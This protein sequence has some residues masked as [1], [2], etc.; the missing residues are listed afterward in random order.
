MNINELV[1][2]PIHEMAEWM[3]NNYKD[4]KGYWSNNYWFCYMNECFKD[5]NFENSD[6]RCIPTMTGYTCRNYGGV[7]EEI[8]RDRF[9]SL[10]FSIAKI[11][12]YGECIIFKFSGNLVHT[13]GNRWGDNYGFDLTDISFNTN[14]KIALSRVYIDGPDIVNNSQLS[15]NF[16]LHSEGPYEDRENWID[17]YPFLDDNY[18]VECSVKPIISSFS[19]NKHSLQEYVEKIENYAKKVQDIGKKAYYDNK[20]IINDNEF[21]KKCKKVHI[22]PFEVFDLWLALYIENQTITFDDAIGMIRLSESKEQHIRDYVN[23]YKCDIVEK[24]WDNKWTLRAKYSSYSPYH[25]SLLFGKV[26]FTLTSGF[27]G[28]LKKLDKTRELYLSL[29]TYK[30]DIKN[31]KSD[32]K[33]AY[34]LLA[35]TFENKILDIYSEINKK[36]EI[37]KDGYLE[38]SKEIYNEIHN[39][40]PGVNDIDVGIYEDIPDI[41]NNIHKAFETTAVRL[42]RKINPNYKGLDHEKLVMKT[43]KKKDDDTEFL[44]HCKKLFD[45]SPDL[46]KIVYYSIYK[47]YDAPY[48]IYESDFID[49]KFSEETI[50]DYEEK[51]GQ[52]SFEDWLTIFISLIPEVPGDYR[53]LGSDLYPGCSYNMIVNRNL[54][55]DEETIND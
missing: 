10:Q 21:K 52:G 22:D 37:V 48:E 5:L 25:L 20:D 49:E 50:Y 33:D 51:Y 4:P 26:S 1:S 27:L 3:Y 38:K 8:K 30:D 6:W 47:A 53:D 36:I 40:Y 23:K 42:M 29:D 39:K 9:H 31:A 17:K 32:Y 44:N 54:E 11:S 12:K 18:S 45:A 24:D 43:E 2:M 41:V 55:Y 14:H 34:T 15:V 16:E 19:K 7:L 13:D 35:Q 46:Q 28:Y